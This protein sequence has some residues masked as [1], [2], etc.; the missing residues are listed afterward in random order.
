MWGIIQYLWKWLQS[1]WV[2]SDLASWLAVGLALMAVYFALRKLGQHTEL[3]LT[4]LH[5]DDD[6]GPISL[7][8]ELSTYS[9]A[10]HLDAKARLKIGGISY[11]MT[12]EPLKTPTNWSFATLNTFHLRFVGQ[13][14]KHKT[15]PTTAFINVKARWSDGSRARLR[16]KIDLKPDEHP[17][18]PTPDKG[19]S[20]TEQV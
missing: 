7:E 9:H 2:Q 16:R 15:T 14:V 18:E 20:P 1:Q 6:G 5:F 11:P 10:P 19:D 12:L 4:R 8:V 3:N 17:S 13:Y